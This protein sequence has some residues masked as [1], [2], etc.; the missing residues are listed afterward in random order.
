M[1]DLRRI[2][3]KFGRYVDVNKYLNTSPIIVS[4]K[5]LNNK[6]NSY[7]DERKIKKKLKKIDQLIILDKNKEI[8][9]IK[10]IEE[11]E[12]NSFFKEI[13]IIGMGHVGL[14]LTV[15]LLK[16]FSHLKG[17]EI[18]KQKLRILR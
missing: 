10:N 16:N 1:G 5:N 12:N 4:E 7:L 6:I 15:H 13:T 17:I 14:P 3:G 2:L 8:I 11:I 9:K 18:D